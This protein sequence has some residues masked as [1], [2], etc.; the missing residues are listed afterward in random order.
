MGLKEET[1][2][3]ITELGRRQEVLALALSLNQIPF[4]NTAFS[5]AGLLPGCD[6]STG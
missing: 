3:L 5:E 1:A 6:G 2:W 4:S